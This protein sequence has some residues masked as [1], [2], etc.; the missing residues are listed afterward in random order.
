VIVGAALLV[1]TVLLAI[2]NSDEIFVAFLSGAGGVTMLVACV[3][4]LTVGRRGGR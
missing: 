4:M 2:N 3:V 1:W